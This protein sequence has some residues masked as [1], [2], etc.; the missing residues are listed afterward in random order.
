MSG[1]N[2]PMM[3]KIPDPMPI[4]VTTV[5]NS[6]SPFALSLS[7]R[8]RDVITS[9]IWSETVS[10]RVCR[11]RHRCVLSL[12]PLRY[13]T[14]HVRSNTG[15]GL[16]MP[17]PM[18]DEGAIMLRLQVFAGVIIV[19]GFCFAAAQEGSAEWWHRNCPDN[20][21]GQLWKGVS[22]C[23]QARQACLAE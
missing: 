9:D 23:S 12:R 16:T 17:K 3:P 2:T 19:L 5:L 8:R 4:Q 7:K 18:G 13:C 10:A 11:S 21:C 14:L 6:I 22:T 20:K 15:T 1:S